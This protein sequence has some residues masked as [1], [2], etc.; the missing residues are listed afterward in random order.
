MDEIS[1]EEFAK[2]D[3]RVGKIEAAKKVEGTDKLVELSVDIGTEKRTLVAGIADVYL[4]ES[5]PGKS[6]VVLANLKPRMIRGIESKGMLLAADAAGM[7]VLLTVDKE[8]PVG[9]SIR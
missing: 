5:L 4:P 7:P 9:A 8:A 2:L 1:Y 6:I 3:M